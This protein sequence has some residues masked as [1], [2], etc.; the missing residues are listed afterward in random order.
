MMISVRIR[1]LQKRGPVSYYPRTSLTNSTETVS[2]TTST[3]V[4]SSPRSGQF[5]YLCRCWCS[6]GDVFQFF[7]SREAGCLLLNILGIE[8]PPAWRTGSKKTL[9]NCNNSFYHTK[10]LTAET[11]IM[12]VSGGCV[13]RTDLLSER[14]GLTFLSQCFVLTCKTVQNDLRIC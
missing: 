10:P 14:S 13:R 7:P 6:P 9:I 5:E 1:L 3:A 11:T 12:S 2:W 4:S 8:T